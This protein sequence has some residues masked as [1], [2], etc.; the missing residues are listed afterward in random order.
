MRR[1]IAPLGLLLVLG[2]CANTGVVPM[3]RGTFMISKRSGQIG[4][5]PPIGAKAD[6]YQEAN[7]FCAKSG[8]VVETIKVDETDG[9]FARPASVA[10][11]FRCVPW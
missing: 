7:S 3:D 11:Q 6:V 2:G 9:G 5:G 10:L 8:M 1:F 4:L